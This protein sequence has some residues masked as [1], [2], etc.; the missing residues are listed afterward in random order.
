MGQ[1]FK[2]FMVLLQVKGIIDY[3]DAWY[4]REG[5]LE[6]PSPGFLNN[7][8]NEYQFWQRKAESTWRLFIAEEEINDQFWNCSTEK[9]KKDEHLDKLQAYKPINIVWRSLEA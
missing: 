5:K 3:I 8:M 6:V 2:K 1:L 7:I 9:W 4:K